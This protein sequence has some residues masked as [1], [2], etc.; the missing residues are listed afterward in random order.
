MS[1]KEDHNII[2]KCEENEEIMCET[3]GGEEEEYKVD[4]R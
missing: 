2:E 1:L 3:D 4:E